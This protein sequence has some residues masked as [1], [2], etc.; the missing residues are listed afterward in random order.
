MAPELRVC[1]Y[2]YLVLFSV[3]RATGRG[4]GLGKDHGYNLELC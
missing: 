2:G 3:I 1:M 4:P